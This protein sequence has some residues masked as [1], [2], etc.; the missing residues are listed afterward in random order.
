MG[1]PFVPEQAPDAALAG[2]PDRRPILR[3]AASDDGDAGSTL[4]PLVGPG[5]GAAEARAAAVRWSAC[6]ATSPPRC[7]ALHVTLLV[8]LPAFALL[9]S[10]SSAEPWAATR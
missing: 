5:P 1:R 6:A 8:L 10:G 4:R 3:S 7:I 2:L 9:T